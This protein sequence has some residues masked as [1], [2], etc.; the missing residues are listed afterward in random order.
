MIKSLIPLE[1]QVVYTLAAIGMVSAHAL[2]VF[3]NRS[4]AGFYDDG[5]FAGT[6]FW[7]VSNFVGGYGGLFVWSFAALTQML[8]LFGMATEVNTMV[9]QYGVGYT[10]AMVAMLAGLS[11]LLASEFAYEDLN[12]K[13]STVASKA[14][15]VY[16]AA[17]DERS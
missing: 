2:H 4:A 1:G 13:D 16:N 14:L 5:D 12:N 7:K 8:S 6:N 9:W 11:N 17:Y 3:R 10:G 15:K